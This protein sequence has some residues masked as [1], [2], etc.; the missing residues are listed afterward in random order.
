MNL[1][2]NIGFNVVKTINSQD[3]ENIRYIGILYDYLDQT[4]AKCGP[5]PA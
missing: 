1:N 5:W 3:F 4:W 2:P